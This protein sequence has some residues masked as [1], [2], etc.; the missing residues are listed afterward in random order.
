MYVCLQLLLL[1]EDVPATTINSVSLVEDVPAITVASVSPVEDVLVASVK[2]PL[3]DVPT[4]VIRGGSKL[5]A[6]LS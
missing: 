6:D 5:I 3:E 1:V 4:S 2:L